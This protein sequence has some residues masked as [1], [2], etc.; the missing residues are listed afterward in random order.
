LSLIPVTLPGMAYVVRRIT[1]AGTVST[2]LIE[3]C[4]DE[5]GRPRQRLL[6]NLHGEPT[7]L[8][9]LAKLAALRDDLRKEREE[10]ALEV[11]E[12]N[13][14]YEI[15]TQNVMHGHQYNNTERKEI[16]ILMRQ[17]EGLLKRISKVDRD[18]A[19]IQRG[20]TVIEKHCT[21]TAEEIQTAIKEHKRELYDARCVA[22]GMECSLKERVKK[23][24]AKL[25]RLMS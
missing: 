16:D 7:V 10:L 1:K 12:A 25:R 20:G 22:L 14:L 2:A 3:S 21:A 11:V 13:K 9:A 18:L 17:R 15:V 4:R 24:K 6:A 5:Q 23:A 8:K 19:A